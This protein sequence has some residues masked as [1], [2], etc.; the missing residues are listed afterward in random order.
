MSSD[1]KSPSHAGNPRSNPHTGHR[2]F[3]VSM[4]L[5]LGDKIREGEEEDS[6]ELEE[7]AAH[8][9]ANLED[10]HDLHTL[11]RSCAPQTRISVTVGCS[12]SRCCWLA[13][14]LGPRSRHVS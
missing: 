3:K 14:L 12:A 7:R 9:E 13:L 1:G 8:K 2:L 5:L 4:D 6:S 10:A 11:M